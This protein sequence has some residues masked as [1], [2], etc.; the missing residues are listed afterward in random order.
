MGKST[1]HGNSR[2][3]S[4]HGAKTGSK[5]LE[6]QR[7]IEA[8]DQRHI[9]GP[10]KNSVLSQKTQVDQSKKEYHK[11]VPFYNGHPA[12]AKDLKEKLKKLFPDEKI[13]SMKKDV[14]DKLD[15]LLKM[16]DREAAAASTPGS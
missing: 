2:A 6:D 9:V 7:W 11:D 3:S 12:S 5:T 1:R 10:T 16:N 14:L 13:P 4:Y 8:Q 15:K